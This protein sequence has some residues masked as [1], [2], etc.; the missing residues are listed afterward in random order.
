MKN[1]LM[2]ISVKV[3]LASLLMTLILPAHADFISG[4]DQLSDSRPDRIV[5]HLFTIDYAGGIGNTGEFRFI[6]DDNFMFP[7][8]VIGSDVEI[9]NANGGVFDAPTF[10]L[11]AKIVTLPWTSEPS[12]GTVQVRIKKVTNPSSEGTYDMNIEAGP[13]S[14]ITTHSASYKVAI[15]SGVAVTALVVA[16]QANPTLSNIYPSTNPILITHD[17]SQGMYFYVHDV[18]DDAVS[19]VIVPPATIGGS[20][21]SET[22]TSPVTGTQAGVKVSFIYFA[23]ATRGN[24]NIVVSLSDSIGGDDPTTYNIPIRVTR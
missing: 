12:S 16:D 11:A 9:V 18:N 23:G 4:S 22:P 3:L 21:G 8:F 1:I 2:K 17:S 7:Y 24:D 5:N 15:T 13:D 14:A 19:Y 10:D 6:F 20:I